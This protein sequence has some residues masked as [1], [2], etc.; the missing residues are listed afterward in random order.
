M[1][2]SQDFVEYVVGQMGNAGTVTYRK[3][4]GEYAVYLDKKVV[5]LICQLPHT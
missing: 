4:F 1:S 3:M 5:G 2:S